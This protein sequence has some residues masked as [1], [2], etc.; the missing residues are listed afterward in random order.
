VPEG[1]EGIVSGGL[2]EGLELLGAPG[3]ELLGA[4]TVDPRGIGG[5]DLVA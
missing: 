4:V 2:E 5:L 3:L 1:K